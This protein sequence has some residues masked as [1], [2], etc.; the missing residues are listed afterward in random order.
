MGLFDSFKKFLGEQSRESDDEW[1]DRLGS[2]VKAK[3]F[4][5]DE[6]A[7]EDFDDDDSANEEYSYRIVYTSSV[8]GSGQA[9]YIKTTRKITSNEDARK[10]LIR[11]FS[12]KDLLEGQGKISVEDFMEW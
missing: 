11:Y 9:H 2:R 1:M 5:D 10:E 12:K 8:L 7:D 3:L 4:E 6:V